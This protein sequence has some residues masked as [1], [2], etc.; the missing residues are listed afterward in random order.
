VTVEI[1]EA[2]AAGDLRA[3]EIKLLELARSGDESAFADLAGRYRSELR[4]HSY[5]LTGSLH[6]AD[7]AVQ[8]GLL[9]AWQGLPRFE[10]RGS[11]RSWLYAIVTNAAIDL[12]R[13]RS[14]RELPVEFSPAADPGADLDWPLTDQPWLAPCP[15]DWLTRHTLAS[16]E[17]KY[18]QRE[19]VELAFL[20]ALQHLPPLQRN[21]LLLR[22]VVGFSAAEIAGQLDTSTQAVNSALQR[23]RAALRGR[24]PARSQ[25]AVLRTLGDDR[26]RAIVERFAD[27]IE[28][29]DADTL[30]SMLTHDAS[31]SM[32]PLPTW[33]RGH[34]GIRQHLVRDVLIHGWQ[35]LPA[36]SNGQLAFGSYLLSP[37]QGKY[38]AA[39]LNVLTL[40]GA[41]ARISAVIG[42]QTAEIV[43]ERPP[44]APHPGPGGA[45]N[46]PVPPREAWITG[47]EL[48]PR[49]GLPSELP[50][51]T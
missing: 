2:T 30:V 45:D 23:A 12:L 15:D 42:F 50:Y 18:E 11:L 36:R 44:A 34:E 25:Q 13:H 9:H 3:E 43:T 27:A 16:P 33:Y 29:G 7:D 17:V 32:P 49:F 5:R 46:A 1:K 21:V 10:G 37:T 40:D 6:D 8:D 31:W 47:A 38:I 24:L 20:I 51:R 4:A 41:D 26:T 19:S 14:R 28:R 48:F 35:H 22:E 39:S